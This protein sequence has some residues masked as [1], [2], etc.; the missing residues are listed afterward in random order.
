MTEIR[1]LMVAIPRW[2]ALCR[3]S[4]PNLGL[5]RDDARARAVVLL[6]Q[7]QRGDARDSNQ[8]MTADE[9]D[10]L[11]AAVEL[12]SEESDFSRR[13][14]LG[15][16]LYLHARALVWPDPLGERDDLLHALGSLLRRTAREEDY[17]SA[18]RVL[19]VPPAERSGRSHELGLERP[20]VLV[21][22]ARILWEQ[23]ER[24]PEPLRA[25]AEF[26][27]LHLAERVRPIGAMDEREYFLGEFALIA[28][29]RCRILSR[30]DEARLWLDRAEANFRL[31]VRI[32]ADLSRLA[33]QRLA[34]RIEE[35]VYDEILELAPPLMESFRRLG[36]EEDAV[37]CGFLT[38][39]ALQ[40]LGR[41]DEAIDLFKETSASSLRRGYRKLHAH[42]ENN[43]FMLY[44]N[45]GDTARALESCS[46]A[47]TVLAE[48]G[49][50]VGLA[51]V[52]WNA[53][54]LLRTQG[55]TKE[56]VETYRSAL[57][58]FRELGMRGEVAA[59]HLVVAD[60]LLNQGAEA[61][62]EWEI[63]AALPIIDEEKMVPEGMAA[64]ALLRESVRRRKIDQNALRDVQAF[65]R[66]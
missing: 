23:I 25:E 17:D 46:I 7:L 59:L 54:S 27:Y 51:R 13:C 9:I 6:D 19:Q 32:Q 21:S 41:P 43:L 44:A 60:L 8:E 50:R 57:D 29:T 37:K 48:L 14:A 40:E 24:D 47:S 61:Q 62:A 18:A 34:L 36:M 64:Y 33:Y 53:G 15:Y 4:A 65:F 38:G 52:Q 1:S 58:G 66:E 55:R 16:P 28:G 63:R 35:R 39:L 22:L 2:L 11:H 12:L 42:A 3:I 45:R 10:T 49:N 26:F 56:A 5:E 20:E 30:R 31:T